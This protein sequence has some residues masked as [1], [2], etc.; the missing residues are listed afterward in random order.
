MGQDALRSAGVGFITLV[1]VP[2]AAAFAC[3]LVI[4]IPLVV[5]AGLLFAVVVYLA[6]A[7]VAIFV[8][9]LILRRLG[10]A[11]RSPYLALTIGIPALYL[12]FAIPFLGKIAWFATTF[13]GLGAIVLNQDALVLPEEDGVRTRRA[14]TYPTSGRQALHPKL[15]AA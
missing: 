12:L 11:N 8:G 1:V 4:T 14:Y 2:V 15:S 13:I 3:I 6:K 10:S 5:I 7:P 9:E